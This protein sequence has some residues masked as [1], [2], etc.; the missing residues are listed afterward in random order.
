MNRDR[1]IGNFS[2][3]E[4]LENAVATEPDLRLVAEVGEQVLNEW[5]P[6]SESLAS[7]LSLH[8]DEIEGT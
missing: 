2:S 4:T 6:G 1:V 3:I 8:S 5:D 7:V